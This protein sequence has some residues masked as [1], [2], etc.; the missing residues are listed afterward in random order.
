MS[1]V[2]SAP[3]S[4]ADSSVAEPADAD[5]AVAA[6]AITANTLEDGEAS[7]ADRQK[8]FRAAVDQGMRLLTAREHTGRELIAKLCRKGHAKAVA[9]EALEHLRAQGLQS[10]E[11][12]A[13][14]YCHSRRARGY[15]PL[16]LDAE[17]RERG[18]AEALIEQALATLDAD[19]RGEAERARRKRFGAALPADRDAWGRQA[20][21]LA[22]RGFPSDVIR[23]LLDGREG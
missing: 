9:A 21:F 13:E 23:R 8:A 1:R 6:K 19:W 10:D 15:G 7:A 18:L 17:L 5:S 4:F 22:R 2:A 16:A 11:R 12:F 20:R 14:S 3:P